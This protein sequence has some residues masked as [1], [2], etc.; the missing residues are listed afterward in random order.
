L[1]TTS[2]FASEKEWR[3]P[4]GDLIFGGGKKN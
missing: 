3:S 4:P 2:F 1:K